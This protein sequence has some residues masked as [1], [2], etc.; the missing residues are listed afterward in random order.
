[1]KD[2]EPIM[3]YRMDPT[4][5]KA[6]KIALM[7]QEECRREIPGEPYAKISPK[8]DPRKST[9]FKYCFK[10]AR[11]T[12]GIIPE[13]DLCLYVRAQIQVL[14][15][16]KDGDVHALI[17][18]HCLVGDKAWRR[19]KVW[20]ARYD[21]RM[22]IP[23]GNPEAPPKPS[24]GK[25][26]AEISSAFDFLSKMGCLDFDALSGRK[27]DLPRWIR[28]GEVSCFWAVLSPWARKVLGDPSGVGFDHVYYRSAVSPQTE[29]Y[30][31]EKFA[32]EFKENKCQRA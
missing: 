13:A 12:S 3:K 30:F 25:I 6:Y 26:R 5:S 16:I 15:G 8:S 32:H 29:L 1:M 23:A 7:W 22:A 4:E 27:D 18:P 24:E 14:K 10:L 20:K 28:G 21:K 11:E 19:W 31:R 2:L 9:L 17:E